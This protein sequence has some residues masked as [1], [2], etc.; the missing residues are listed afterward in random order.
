MGFVWKRRE[1]LAMACCEPT[2]TQ[3]ATNRLLMP[4]IKAPFANIALTFEREGERIRISATFQSHQPEVPAR[5]DRLC[6]FHSFPWKSALAKNDTARTGQR[7]KVA[8]GLKSTFAF[9]WVSRGG[10]LMPLF[11][12]I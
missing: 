1:P 8:R 4:P 7:E 3:P 9:A 12:D 2:A 10:A 5:P 6:L 11:V